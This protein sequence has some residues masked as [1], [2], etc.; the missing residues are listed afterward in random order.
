MNNYKIQILY[1]I[2]FLINYYTIELVVTI[3][4]KYSDLYEM[5]EIFFIK[6]YM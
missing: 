3:F 6:M 5:D 1:K 2:I 4:N